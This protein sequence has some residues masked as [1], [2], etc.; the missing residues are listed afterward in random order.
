MR[1]KVVV[2]DEASV[3]IGSA[4]F[5]ERSQQRNIEAGALLHDAAFACQLV[6]QLQSLIDGDYVKR[7][8]ARGGPHHAGQPLTLHGLPGRSWSP[9]GASCC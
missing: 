1:A 6:T 9:F 2:I 5:T 4:N 7:D 3:F 8:G